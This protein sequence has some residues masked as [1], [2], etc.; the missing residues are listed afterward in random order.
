MT[1][2]IICLI[3]S[4]VILLAVGLCGLFGGM[5]KGA[6]RS[7]VKLAA[8]VLSVVIALIVSLC[9]RGVLANIIR[10]FIP[11][12]LSA[13]PVIVDL[14]VQIPAAISLLIAF[15]VIFSIVRLLM[16]IPQ[17]II[18]RRL[19]R[20]FDELTRKQKKH[21]PVKTESEMTAA[22]TPTASQNL[23]DRTTV[24][25]DGD[26]LAEDSVAESDPAEPIDT[27]SQPTAE[28]VDP[29]VT[30]PITEQAQ[31][32]NQRPLRILWK[33]AG[34]LCG[35]LSS[36]LL[37]G[38]LI[39]PLSG[40]ITR[41]GNT[42]YRITDV[43][44]KENYIEYADEVSEYAHAI[45]TAPLFTVTDFFYGKTVF[46]PLTTFPTEYGKIS[47][48][49]ELKT[50]ADI[51][52]EL[53]PVAIHLSEEGTLH[54]GDID[55]MTAGT[56]RIAESKFILSV[57]TYAVHY[58]GNQ[59][60]KPDSQASVGK[61]ALHSELGDVMT[62][63]TP[64]E[65]SADLKTL[66]ALVEVLSESKLLAAL[67]AE[68]TDLS[69]SDLVDRAVMRDAFGILYDN[70]HTKRLA[71]PLINF[72]S[73]AV[74]KLLDATPVYSDTDMDKVS[75]DEM[76]EEA[77]RF[78]DAAEGLAE[79]AKSLQAENA[80]ITSYRMAAAGD[81][82]DCLRE[83]IFFGNQYEA[84][85]RSLTAAGGGA[86]NA[87]MEALGD[88]LVN[89][90]SAKQLLASAESVV[91]MG[92]ALLKSEQKGRENEALVS[93]MDTLLNHT[94]AD[95][96]ETLSNIAG[97]HFFGDSEQTNSDVKTQ[98]IEDSVKALTALS[99]EANTDAAVEA[100]AVQVIYDL[101][102]SSA[103]GIFSSVSE[104]EAADALLSSAIA[105]EMLK[106]L[107][108]EGRDYGIRAKLTAENLDR[109]AA[110]IEASDASVEQKQIVSEFFGVN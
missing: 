47:L 60:G 83:S 110:A 24:I 39:M 64:D 66:T 58:A 28:P 29:I 109:I 35:T 11:S 49:G 80:D 67:T 10:R 72:G 103:E 2:S 12:E 13:F 50:T 75:R 42:I 85:V 27:A 89:T 93:S 108:S 81:A 91:T 18:S 90:S 74:F 63:L 84:L 82:L 44:A 62:E 71:L 37:L 33:V 100:D 26:P 68:D 99:G 45:S 78:C 77:D 53:L 16:L 70:A 19:P 38:A 51:A 7:L 76:L 43:M 55:H 65:L 48:S 4:L 36:L 59:L 105:R 87:L 102:H 32:N 94:S 20:T 22:S 106:T 40:I 79:F 73:E 25:N 8:L 56:E 98:V 1:I 52:C 46:E 107:N 95:D 6:L 5:R 57:G 21:T 9:L 14:I 34:A 54:E 3:V 88:A 104:Q 41:V 23:E 30:T 96:I 97:D 92:D 15:W 86:S 61:Q 17:S 31:S 69:I 101:T